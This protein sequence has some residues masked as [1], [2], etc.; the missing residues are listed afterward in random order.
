KPTGDPAPVIRIGQLV[1]DRAG[2]HPTL[3]LE[4][5]APPDN[6]YK[7]C[8]EDE[9]IERLEKLL[10]AARATR[11]FHREHDIARLLPDA[12]AIDGVVDEGFLVPE[13]DAEP[14]M[15]SD[16]PPIQEV[17]VPFPSGN[18]TSETC[19]ADEEAAK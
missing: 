15:A 11:D 17:A 3:A 6:P 4:Q 5:A 7:D 16:T 9:L 19:K 10:E 18:G 8:T 2:F 13:D 14:A 12:G 1:L